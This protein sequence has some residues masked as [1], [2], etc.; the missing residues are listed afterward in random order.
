MDWDNLCRLK[1]IY[2]KQYLN[3]PRHKHF[4]KFIV[5]I[6]T[7]KIKSYSEYNKM[8]DK[9]IV[10]WMKKK[11]AQAVTLNIPFVCIN[12]MTRK[13]SVYPSSTR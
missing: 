12:E 7:F 9:Q 1:K 3:T 5:Y 10:F 11:T 6:I 4:N 8:H 13:Y 2:L